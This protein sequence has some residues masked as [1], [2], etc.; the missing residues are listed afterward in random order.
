LQDKRTETQTVTKG[1]GRSLSD[2]AHKATAQCVL[3]W[4]K[5]LLD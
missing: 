2:I 5:K 3:S 4:T 1:K